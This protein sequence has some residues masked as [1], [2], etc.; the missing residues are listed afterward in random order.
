VQRTYEELRRA[1]WHQRSCLRDR[2]GPARQGQGRGGGADRA[3]L[4]RWTNAQ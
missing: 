2:R 4:A 1:L 3:A